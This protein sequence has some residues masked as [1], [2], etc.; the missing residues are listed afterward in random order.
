MKR[1]LILIPLLQGCAYESPLLDAQNDRAGFVI[2]NPPMQISYRGDITPESREFT[3][4]VLEKM[5]DVEFH[6]YKFNENHTVI[7]NSIDGKSD[8]VRISLHEYR[9]NTKS[10]ALEPTVED[11]KEIHKELKEKSPAPLLYGGS[12][13][14]TNAKEVL[15][16]LNVDGILVGSAALNVD[17]FCDMI[18]FSE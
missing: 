3:L 6:D 12:V 7:L 9:G 2:T 1:V 13:K 11:I 16:V 17:D 10:D 4:L 18:S 14:V 5:K 8:D 15:A